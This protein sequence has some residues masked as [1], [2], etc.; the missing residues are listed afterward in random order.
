MSSLAAGQK[1]RVRRVH[2]RCARSTIFS[3]AD[4]GDA[5]E[6]VRYLRWFIVAS[7][8]GAAMTALQTGKSGDLA[9]GSRVLRRKVSENCLRMSA[10]SVRAAFNHAAH[11]FDPSDSYL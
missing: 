7:L 2:K 8:T 11:D 5:C 10:V 3:S 1:P 9:E 4:G 6:R